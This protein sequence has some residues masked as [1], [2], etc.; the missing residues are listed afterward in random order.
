MAYDNFKIYPDILDLWDSNEKNNG[1]I[2]N[3]ITKNN[4][5]ENIEKKEKRKILNNEIISK[6]RHITGKDKILKYIL[7][8]TEGIILIIYLYVFFYNYKNSDEYYNL[9]KSQVDKVDTNKSDHDYLICQNSWDGITVNEFAVLASAVY[10]DTK[11]SVMKE[12]ENLRPKTSAINKFKI[13]NKYDKDHHKKKNGLPEC[14]SSIFGSNKNKNQSSEKNSLS[15]VKY[16]DFEYT[17]HNIIVVSIRGTY[18]NEDFIQDVY[19]WG[20]SFLF[21]LSS[22]FGTFLKPSG[23]MS[24]FKKY[25]NLGFA[26][27][28]ISYIDDVQN[29]VQK[30]IDNGK[31]VYL[32]G[33]SLGGGIASKVGATKNI[34]TIVFSAPGIAE[35]YKDSNIDFKYYIKNLLN[36]VPLF[37]IVP[38]VDR[39]IGTIQNIPCSDRRPLSC[40]K[41]INTIL[42]L[43]DMCKKEVFNG[44]YALDYVF[45][46]KRELEKYYEYFN[47]TNPINN[48][49]N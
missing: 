42:T 28:Q 29:H 36:I 44:K 19:I 45:R 35:T 9:V 43:N 8:F 10:Q 41:I 24:Y 12:W 48:N 11:E 25:T 16:Y 39:Q 33:H 27:N 34:Q 18:V 38:L 17:G 46:N 26:Y 22:Y 13:S 30:I 31:K 15:S 3:E 7:S 5:N 49:N 2:D 4:S 14:V 20:D 1:G 37:D 6:E 40:H 21:E 32:T 23:I 47:K